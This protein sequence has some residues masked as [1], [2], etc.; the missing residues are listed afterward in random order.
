MI[1]ECSISVRPTIVPLTSEQC[2]FGLA[3][4]SR[5]TYAALQNGDV[6]RSITVELDR[7]TTHLARDCPSSTS[8]SR[9]L[10]LPMYR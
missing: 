8:V 3:T 7:L 1:A 4:Q 6:F 5:H 9:D 10:L 2:H